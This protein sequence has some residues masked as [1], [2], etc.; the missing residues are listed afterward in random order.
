MT[1]LCR[2]LPLTA[3]LLAACSTDE[4]GN[5]GRVPVNLT[6]YVG[7]G[8]TR[9][10]TAVQGTQF[11]E[12]ETFRVYFPE[13]VLPQTTTYTTTDAD[14]AIQPDIQPYFEGNT[15]TAATVYAYYPQTVTQETASFSVLKDQTTD[16]A[17]KASD[18]MYATTSLVKTSVS[19]TG[20]LLF[21]H[22]MAKLIV[23]V[24]ADKSITAITSV[25]IV[26]GY[27]SIVIATPLTCTLS[28]DEDDLSD[29]ISATDNGGDDYAC[30]KMYEDEE[31]ANHVQCA[32]L[33]PPQTISA[34]NLI[35][36][37][38]VEGTV[39]YKL[40]AAKPLA[41][42]NTYT[43]QLAVKLSDINTTAAIT[44]W[45]QETTPITNYPHNVFVIDDIADET[46]TGE[47]ITPNPD[48]Y[49]NNTKLTKDTDYYLTY[50][51]NT[52]VGTATITVVGINIYAGKTATKTFKINSKQS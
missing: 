25:R 35:E 4:Q 11:D 12:G 51:N 50:S 29:V 38:T 6:A 49:Y 43:M 27:R 39:T 31:G 18:L 36:I 14:G 44:N 22:K 7:Q 10:G 32:A 33:L 2:L 17:Y 24:T 42:G 47:P 40:T 34:G 9:G 28:T 15:T 41:G 26:S 16:A 3:L 37:R 46:E 13:N 48:V 1:K 30:V 20:T 23:D 21:E 5:G 52:A 8:P 45:T 19:A